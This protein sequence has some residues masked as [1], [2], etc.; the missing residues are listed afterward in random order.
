MGF[1]DKNMWVENETATN[2]CVF[3]MQCQMKPYQYE[4]IQRWIAPLIQNKREPEWKSKQKT[5]LVIFRI[6]LKFTNN[7]QRGEIKTIKCITN[8]F[9]CWSNLCL[10]KC[11]QNRWQ[12]DALFPVVVGF[13][14]FIFYFAFT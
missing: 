11:T 4:Y 7:Q 12:S 5:N 1:C 10:C 3:I 9:L 14:H 8:N 13:A 2:L 6:Q